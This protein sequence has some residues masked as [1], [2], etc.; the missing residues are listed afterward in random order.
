MSHEK[1]HKE[2]S[3]EE[4]KVKELTE[5]LQRLQAEFEN[6]RKRTEKE[7]ADYCRYAKSDIIQK[8][9]PIVDNFELAMKNTDK[10]DDFIKGIGMVY[11]HFKDVLRKEGVEEIEAVGKQFDPNLHEAMLSEP[12]EQEGVVLDE[13]QKGYM[14]EDRVL[15]HTQVKVGTK[16]RSDDKEDYNQGGSAGKGC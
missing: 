14:L 10:P 16:K 3:K 12:S 1:K 6:F 4:D 2:Q 15:R 8:L 11:A 13:L 9:L 5:D 7:K